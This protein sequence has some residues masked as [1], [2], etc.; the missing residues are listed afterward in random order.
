[1]EEKYVKCR[2]VVSA[3]AMAITITYNGSLL[4]TSKFRKMTRNKENTNCL[5][6]VQLCKRLTNYI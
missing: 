3:E 1:M 5:Y 4:I 2:K 6:H